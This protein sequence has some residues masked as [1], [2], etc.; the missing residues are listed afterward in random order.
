MLVHG[1]TTWRRLGFDWGRHLAIGPPRPPRPK[2]NPSKSTAM[3]KEL[4]HLRR[5]GCGACLS[6]PRA[7]RL[8]RL[9]FRS[10]GGRRV[11]VR[12]LP[13]ALSVHQPTIRQPTRFSP[14]NSRTA[15]SNHKS[16]APRCSSSTAPR[17]VRF[18]PTA[19]IGALPASLARHDVE[20]SS[21]AA[22]HAPITAHWGRQSPANAAARAAKDRSGGGE[23]A[24]GSCKPTGHRLARSRGLMDAQR[25]NAILDAAPRV[26]F[27]LVGTI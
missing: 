18:P 16:W 22:W 13:A 15:M 25:V 12:G 23:K 27:L 11:R 21:T 2:S 5:A 3:S 19:S 7:A 24:E 10:T 9:M 6:V 14:S 17:P 20:R 4:R 8:T 1:A 26:T